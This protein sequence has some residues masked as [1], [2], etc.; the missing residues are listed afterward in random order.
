[1]NPLKVMKVLEKVWLGVGCITIAMAV[2]AAI[3]QDWTDV[4]FML[5]ATAVAGLIYYRRRKQRMWLERDNK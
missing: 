4:M 5:I 2:Y 3:R 1:M